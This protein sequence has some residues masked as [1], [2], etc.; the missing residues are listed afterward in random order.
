MLVFKCINKEGNFYKV[1]INEKSE[2][3]GF[4][5]VTDKKFKFQ[6]KEQH[7]LS[8]FSIDFD[9]NKNPIRQQPSKTSSILLYDKDEFYIPT[10]ISGDWVMV[11]WGSEGDWNYGWVKW[12]END[13][14]LIELFYFA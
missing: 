3:I 13:A 10:K 5:H 9:S 4:I 8:A 14:W 7:I 2:E 1:I 6:T 12:Q 11:K